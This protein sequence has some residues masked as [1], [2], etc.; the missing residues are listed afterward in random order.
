VPD[1]VI[2][3]I[4]LRVVCA[5]ALMQEFDEFVATLPVWQRVSLRIK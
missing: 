1:D 3:A 5:V 4:T 2:M